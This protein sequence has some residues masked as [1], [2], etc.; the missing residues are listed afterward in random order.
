MAENSN[1]PEGENS[2]EREAP[3]DHGADVA[4]VE[5][6]N[7]PTPSETDSAFDDQLSS[8]TASLTSSVVN[9]PM[10]HGR[11][12]HAFREGSYNFPNDEAWSSY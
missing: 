3:T 7:E 6:D 2:P 4:P 12:Y 11:R 8:Y 1:S 5:V 10:E 9:Y